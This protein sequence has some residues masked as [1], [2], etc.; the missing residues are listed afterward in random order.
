MDYIRQLFTKRFTKF[1]IVGGSGALI[2]LSLTWLLTESVGLWYILSLTIAVVI[3]TVWN[4]NL[5]ARWT[6]AQYKN[7]DDADYEWNSFF[8]GNPAQKWWK[9]SIA[10]TVWKFIPQSSN[11]LDIGCGSSPTI[12]KYKKAV[13]IDLNE[14]KL[15]FMQERCDPLFIQF[16][17]MDARRLEFPDAFFDTVICIE[18][19]EHLNPEDIIREI[20]RVLKPGGLTVIATPDYSRFWWYLAEKFTPYKTQHFARLSRRSLLKLCESYHLRETS[21][22]HILGCDYVGL[23]KKI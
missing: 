23:F 15:R 7:P 3:A 9:Q 4:F 12:T 6:F 11:L 18:V 10:R 16:V 22:H 21:H 17:K 14:E 20:E 8:K 13:G 5:N 19:L 1:C 2:T